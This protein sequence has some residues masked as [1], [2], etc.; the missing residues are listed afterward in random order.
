MSTSYEPGEGSDLV[1]PAGTTKEFEQEAELAGFPLTAGDPVKLLLEPESV[2]DNCFLSA[3]FADSLG[4]VPIPKT[5][6]LPPSHGRVRNYKSNQAV[7]DANGAALQMLG[8]SP[9]I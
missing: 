1:F 2:D 7:I 4:S 5:A 9:G 8:H 6:V 3:V